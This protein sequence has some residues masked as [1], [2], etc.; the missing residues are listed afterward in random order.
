[1]RLL[2]RKRDVWENSVPMVSRSSRFSLGQ[3][4]VSFIAVE[5]TNHG[6][7]FSGVLG[8]LEWRDPRARKALV[9][10]SAQLPS[11]LYKVKAW[12]AILQAQIPC[13]LTHRGTLRKS[14]PLG[15]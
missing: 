2:E 3:G 7:Y 15:L 5:W 10:S 6:W 1:M 9:S 14:L 11:A 13:L 12:A 4:S 8:S